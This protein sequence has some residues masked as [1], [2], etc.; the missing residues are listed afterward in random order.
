[1]EYKDYYKILGVD[2]NASDKQIKAAYRKLA[3]KYHPDVNPNNPQAEAKFKEINEANEVLSDPTKRSKY[4][5]LGADWQH[6]QQTGGRPNDFN[7]GQY[8]TG[9]GGER[10]HV[11]YA[12]PEDL[13]DMFGGGSPFSDF[14][15]S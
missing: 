1:M 3:R 7:W 11:R 6:W 12:T 8:T 14:F 10:V 4:D 13:E 2:K 15:T 9:P 5:Q